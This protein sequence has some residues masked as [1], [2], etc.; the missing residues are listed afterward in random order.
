MATTRSR[1]ARTWPICADRPTLRCAS[2]QASARDKRLRSCSANDWP[3]RRVHPARKA[4][5]A[6]RRFG[7]SDCSPSPIHK[8]ISNRRNNG[9]FPRFIVPAA[10]E[11]D[12]CLQQE[13]PLILTC[14]AAAKPRRMKQRARL[15]RILRG[16]VLP[17]TSGCGNHASQ[18]SILSTV[19]MIGSDAAGRPRP[20]FSF[21][22]VPI[23]PSFRS[24]RK[25]GRAPIRSSGGFR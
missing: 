9:G 6:G 16:P 17:G 2:R 4:R 11:F 20:S 14:F 18:R 19:G 5:S 22:G 23:S 3:G 8:F 12:S 21:N 7:Q 10:A 25:S 1:S 15:H 24:A 13:E